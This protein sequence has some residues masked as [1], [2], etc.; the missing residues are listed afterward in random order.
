MLRTEIGTVDTPYDAT[1]AGPL[2]PQLGLSKESVAELNR[3]SI[4]GITEYI[5]TVVSIC[6]ASAWNM[7]LAML[8][9]PKMF[10]LCTGIWP[11]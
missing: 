10:F 4:E 6:N 1:R 2:C 5:L 3:Q 7:S 9:G 11:H 8:I